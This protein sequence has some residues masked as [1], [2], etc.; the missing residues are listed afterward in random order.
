MIT[1]FADC[2]SK[3]AA[4]SFHEGLALELAHVYKARRVRTSV[5]CPGHIRT[6]MFAGFDTHLPH[7]LAPSLEVE[8]VAQL[9]V[10]TVLSGQSQVSWTIPSD[11]AQRG[12]S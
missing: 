11:L 2:S 12:D 9:I 10:D 1:I 6:A 3:A 7:W 8:T 5:I 4:L